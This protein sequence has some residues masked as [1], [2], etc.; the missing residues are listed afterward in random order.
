MNDDH[1]EAAPK[2]LVRTD[3]L[4]A[5]AD[6]DAAG[7]IWKLQEP[8]R[9]LDSNVIAL[10]PAGTIETHTGPDLDVLIHVL[11]G[12]GTLHAANADIALEP[13][14]LMWLPKRSRRGFTAGSAGLRYLTVH[15]K[16]PA[17]NLQPPPA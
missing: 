1:P 5:E 13:G 9:D 8:E 4:M 12:E 10:P 7:A 16:R 14:T 11:S 2:V 6:D 17:L 3:Q 15:R